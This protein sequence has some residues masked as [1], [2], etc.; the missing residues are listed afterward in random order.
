[1]TVKGEGVCAWPSIVNVTVPVGVPV[2]GFVT[3]AVYVTFVPRVDGLSDEVKAVVV[4]WTENCDVLPLGSVAVAVTNVSPA[5]SVRPS[6]KLALPAEPVVTG[7][8][9]RKVWPSGTP[10][11]EPSALAKNSMVNECRC[12]GAR[13]NGLDAAARECG[14]SGQTL[15]PAPGCC[16]RPTV[17][18]WRLMPSLVLPKIEFW[19]IVSIVLLT[20][21]RTPS[22]PLKAM[23]LVHSWPIHRSYCCCTNVRSRRYP[24]CPGWAC[25]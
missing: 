18:L 22:S 8:L 5:G 1:M 6:M 13:S 14:V 17:S 4:A 24:Y 9:V 2:A 20:T 15:V 11:D 16:H 25:L 10:L 21:T 12:G 19:L 3:T 7:M 23:T